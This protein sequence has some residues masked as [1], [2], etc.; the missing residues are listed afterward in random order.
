VGPTAMSVILR[1]SS[2]LLLCIGIQILWNG[3]QALLKT[4]PR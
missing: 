1:L 4:L 3:V 2:F